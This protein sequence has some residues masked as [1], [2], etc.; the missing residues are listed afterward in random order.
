MIAFQAQHIGRNVSADVMVEAVSGYGVT[1]SSSPIQVILDNTLGFDS[2]LAWDYSSWVPDAV[3]I[4]IGPN[5]EVPLVT[6]KNFVA[7]YLGQSRL[8]FLRAPCPVPLGM[9]PQETDAQS[10]K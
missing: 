2:D 10:D 4:L 1:K 9:I 7:S 3:V 6:G 8:Y 5:D